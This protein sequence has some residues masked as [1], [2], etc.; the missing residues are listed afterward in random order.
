MLGPIGSDIMAIF[1]LLSP[2]EIDRYIEVTKD[3][4]VAMPMAANGEALS[5]D[6]DEPHLENQRPKK[7]FNPKN[8]AKII[9]INKYKKAREPE[10]TSLDE[11]PQTNQ[12]RAQN[13]PAQEQEHH[14]PEGNSELESIGVLSASTIR[15]IEEDRLK[16]EKKKQDSSTVFLIKERQKMR[17]SKKKLIRQD[18]FKTYQTS[19][20]QTYNSSSLEEED[21]SDASDTTESRGILV[22]KRHY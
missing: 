11:E 6:H 17:D 1:R 9:S 10:P 5:F 3:S 14:A 20:T 19:S 13:H 7:K 21:E 16:E 22:N 12:I 18:A 2:D 4:R 8:K 15:D